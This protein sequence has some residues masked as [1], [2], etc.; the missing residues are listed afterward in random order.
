MM[1]S[2]QLG[3]GLLCAV[4]GMAISCAA[5]DFTDIDLRIPIDSPY[6]GW[7]TGGG[8]SRDPG[9]GSDLRFALKP[10]EYRLLVTL[11]D[12]FLQNTEHTNDT[13]TVSMNARQIGVFHRGAGKG[14]TT[15]QTTIPAEAFV[16]GATQT[17]HFARSRTPIPIPI[18]QVRVTATDAPDNDLLRLPIDSQYYC[19]WTTGEPGWRDAGEGSELRFELKPSKPGKYRLL[20]TLDDSQKAENT[21]D[22]LT[23]SMNAREIAVFHRGATN[24]WT[25]WQTLIPTE[26]V[27]QGRQRLRFVRHG[28]AIPISEVRIHGFFV[29]PPPPLGGLQRAGWNLYADHFMYAPT[30]YAT[31]M[32][33]AKQY[34]LTVCSSD[35]C[36]QRR[37]TASKP[38]LDLASVWADLPAKWQYNVWI[39]ALDGQGTVIGRTPVL[40]FLKVEEF[41]G[42][43]RKAR[44]GYIE[45]GSK[46]AEGVV[47]A[48]HGW[49]PPA[50]NTE[51]FPAVFYTSYIRLLVT[52]AQLPPKSP[53]AAEALEL[54]N[55]FGKQL[56]AS[57]C[58][59]EW[60]Y[61]G[62]PQTHGNGYHFM[63]VHRTAMAGKAYLDLLAA[64]G[65]PAYRAA[66]LRL[67]DALARTQLP[68]GRWYWRVDPKTGA[69]YVD[70]GGKTNDYTSD[71]AEIIDFLDE[72][73]TH[74]N[75]QDLIPA[76]DRAV[77]WMLDNPVKTHYWQHQWD[78][79]AYFKPYENLE[80]YD[81]AL[82]AMY[83]ARHATWRNG[84]R[85]IAENLFRWIEDQFVLWENSYAPMD[86]TPG[87]LEQYAYRLTIDW[88]SSHYILL[89]MA[90]HKTTGKKIY[91]EK[92]RAMADTLTVVQRAA[93][94]S[95]P[96]YLS[97]SELGPDADT[98]GP[99]SC[100]ETWPNCNSYDGET[101]MKLGRYLRRP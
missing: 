39:E 82:F 13:L 23:V 36:M 49:Q 32:L 7:T 43:Y 54:A 64:T 95:Y 90:M 29:K 18:S 94:G 46:C 92:A 45:S 88:H 5:L 21:N 55:R 6:R 87:V 28:N 31:A 53:H 44:Y 38:E 50:P 67:G 81:T 15:W 93:D 91:L 8:G 20:V 97:Q 25:T 59:P 79:T 17:L 57:T 47:N 1:M 11:W 42:P 41:K 19:G 69:P 16:E 96:T 51:R 78:D 34:A 84:Y 22:T 62:M 52:Y 60:A 26:T 63:Q 4:L 86:V 27:E 35:G 14:W 72:L 10:G 61:G 75:R 83:L 100:S 65:E 48:Q 56:I 37:L 3:V 68:E 58:P 89:C 76:R 85:A 73:A 101:L 12:D 2:K 33:A 98:L 99:I 71:Q 74:Y 66:A 40:E 80:F 70:G 24:G 9:E 77:K 30:L